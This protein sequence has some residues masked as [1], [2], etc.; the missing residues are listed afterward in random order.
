MD[1]KTVETFANFG[2]SEFI[3]NS[4]TRAGFLTPTEVQS[5]SIGVILEGRDLMASAQTGSGKTAAYAVP[6]IDMLK[7]SIKRHA[8]RALVVVP[9][10]ELALQVKEQFYKLGRHLSVVAIYGGTGYLRQYRA[11]ERGADIVVATP[12]RLL[13]L[14]DQKVVSLGSSTI[15]VLDE[16]DRLMDMGFMPQIRQL[17]TR[18][19]QQRQTLMFSATIDKRIEE[20]AAEF[21]SNPVV[22]RSTAVQVDPSS[23]EQKIHYLT[24]SG[25]EGLLLELLNVSQE[26]SVL[27][28]TKTREKAGELADFL[29]DSNIDAEEIHGE[30]NQRR[31]E[32]IMCRYRNREFNVL[33]ATDIAA[34]G[35]DVP[36]ISHVINYD[37]PTCAEDYVHRIGRTGRAGRSGVAHSFV[38]REQLYLLKPIEHV[39]GRQFTEQPSHEWATLRKRDRKRSTSSRRHSDSRAGRF[40]KLDRS[41]LEEALSMT[42]GTRE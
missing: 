15:L 28:F 23:I 2:L 40:R 14:V 18:V 16:A 36:H 6:I 19:P 10:R 25:K 13:D 5:Q 21:L 32:K 4:L 33:V 7:R 34:R 35:L 29:R 22:I 9:T 17:V 38:S 42:F 39:L 27:I 31:R 24:E 11:F 26:S 20:L 8:P 3:Q 30:I 12:G 37:L 41:G 1:V